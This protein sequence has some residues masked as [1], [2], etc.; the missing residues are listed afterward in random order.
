VLELLRPGGV[1]ALDNMMP[2]GVWDEATRGP[3]ARAV[4]PVNLKIRDD[5]RVHASPATIG[6]GM[7][8]ARKR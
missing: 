1:M 4:H 8:L 5:S 3:M 6:G 7:M 2:N